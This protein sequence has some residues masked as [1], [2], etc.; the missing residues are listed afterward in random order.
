MIEGIPDEADEE[1]VLVL[2]PDRRTTTSAPSCCRPLTT[3]EGRLSLPGLVLAVVSSDWE[4]YCEVAFRSDEEVLLL[5]VKGDS[6]PESGL[7]LL[8]TVDE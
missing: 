8:V 3:V 5:L 2:L 6:G 7:M 4:E 1:C